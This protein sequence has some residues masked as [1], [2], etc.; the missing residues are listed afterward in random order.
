MSTSSPIFRFAPSPNGH[1]HLG[2]AL[3]ALLNCRAAER[4]GGTCLLRI[5]NIDQTRCTPA[6]EQEML[7]DLTWIGARFSGPVLRQSERFDVYRAALERLERDGLTYRSYLTRGEIKRFIADREAEGLVWPRDPDGAPLYPGDRTVLEADEIRRRE[8]SDMPFAIRLDMGK[9]LAR[10]GAMPDWWEGPA[11]L[12]EGE[13]PARWMEGRRIPAEPA[14][15]GDV[16]LGRKDCPTSYHLS[17]VVDDAE[18]GV[19]DVLRGQDL[20]HATSVH[21][22]LQVLLGLPELRYRHHRLILDDE[23]RKLSKSLASASLR[24]LRSS[25]VTERE[26]MGRIGL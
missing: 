1:L 14:A 23:G 2:H 25:G 7:E 5:E 17:V 13:D 3:S 10:L 12:G 19:T 11:E 21:R 15:W 4:T 24:D 6:L 18:Q 9:A 20:Y 26:V 22:L 8:A 16:V